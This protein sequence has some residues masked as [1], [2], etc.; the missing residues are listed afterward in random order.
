MSATVD[1]GDLLEDGGL[2]ADAP[3]DDFSARG[4]FRV[5]PESWTRHGCQSLHPDLRRVR[6]YAV[7]VALGDRD[8]GL[9]EVEALRI[10]YVRHDA[11][12]AL[13]NYRRTREDD[14][15]GTLPDGTFRSREAF[16]PDAGR[17]VDDDLQEL[18]G[19]LL[20]QLYDAGPAAGGGE[21]D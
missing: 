12:R 1:P 11:Q 7:L 13:S 17:A 15:G 8:N 21:G 5:L 16:V 6:W 4:E 10:V 20:A 2:A 18:F 14:N 19:R 9:G 3:Q